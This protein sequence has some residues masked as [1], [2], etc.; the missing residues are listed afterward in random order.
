MLRADGGIPRTGQ[1]PVLDNGAHERH[2]LLAI[3]FPLLLGACTVIGH[4]KVE[5]WPQLTVIEHHV[6][7]HV[8]RD[9]CVKYA[10]W[11]SSPEACAEFNLAERRCDLW[12]SA[13]FPPL[14]TFVEHERMHCDGYDHVGES[15]MRDFLARYN[16]E[17]ANITLARGRA[18]QPVR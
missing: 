17:Q 16:A 14:P 9:R 11:G 13:D 15:N 8:M 7:H 1:Q 18:E 6:P 10:P 4:Q 2:A 12:F 3:L 5:G